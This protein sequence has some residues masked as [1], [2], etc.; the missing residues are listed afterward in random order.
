MGAGHQRLRSE[1]G[2]RPN[3]FVT[4]NTPSRR[5]LRKSTR[6]EQPVFLQDFLR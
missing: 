4:N 3:V 5:P 6:P 2:Q 1:A